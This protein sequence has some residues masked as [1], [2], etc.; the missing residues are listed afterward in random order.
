[1]SFYH[2]VAKHQG[3]GINSDTELVLA[4]ENGL[5]HNKAKHGAMY[6]PCLL[7]KTPETICP[8]KQWREGTMAMCHC[9][10]YVRE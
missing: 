7:A 10:L 8:C 4:I 2:K 3:W 6:C 9:G 1:M 5:R